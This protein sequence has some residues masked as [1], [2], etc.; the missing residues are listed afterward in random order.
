MAHYNKEECVARTET[1]VLRKMLSL[2]NA[3]DIKMW[4]VETFM[5]N[6]HSK[7]N[8]S[9]KVTIGRTSTYSMLSHVT[10]LKSKAAL[11]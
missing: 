9:L 3:N 4:E 2:W 6:T 10:A 5:S 11:T 7:E 8:E 1:D